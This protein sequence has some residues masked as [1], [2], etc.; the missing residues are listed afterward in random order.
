MAL[1]MYS[2]FRLVAES[3]I[4]DR[5][6]RTNNKLFSKNLTSRLR[7]YAYPFIEEEPIY[8]V[9]REQLLTI[10]DYIRASGG[11]ANKLYLFFDDLKRIFRY[12]QRN[13]ILISNPCQD[14]KI[15]YQ[16]DK[17][18][19]HF[20]AAEVAALHL[21]FS[22]CELQELF[23][24]SFIS[25]LPIR[26]SAALKTGSV[27]LT[28]GICQI[29]EEV[30]YNRCRHYCSELVPAKNQR[31]ITLAD[32]CVNYLKTVEQNEVGIFFPGTNH[33]LITQSDISACLMTIQ[34]YSGI[35]DF[36]VHQMVENYIYECLNIG[37][38]TVS[39]EEYYGYGCGYIN[40]AFACVDPNRAEPILPG[41]SS[42][43]IQ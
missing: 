10:R 6:E 9:T 41:S 1:T 18:C 37:V 30:H 8:K 23:V 24:F 31:V 29:T 21:G 28:T 34:H 15:P 20:S 11:S 12:A 4:K 26:E 5:E 19:R 39:L 36:T 17:R 38:D 27:D 16:W 3:Y 25:G 7:R 40:N 22:K 2:S 13:L 33:E 32:E 42:W 43:R 14:I 35:S